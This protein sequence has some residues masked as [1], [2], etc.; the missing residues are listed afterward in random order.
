MNTIEHLNALL[1][2]IE[3]HRNTLEHQAKLAKVQ[4]ANAFIQGAMKDVKEMAATIQFHEGGIDA[5]DT[6]IQIVQDEIHRAD[7]DAPDTDLPPAE[8]NAR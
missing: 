2:T 8:G 5:L 7:P 6:A 1:R 4:L 3:N